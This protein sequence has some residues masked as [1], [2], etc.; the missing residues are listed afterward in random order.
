MAVIRH[1]RGISYGN[2]WCSN[3]EDVERALIVDC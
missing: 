1:I 3:V 2:R